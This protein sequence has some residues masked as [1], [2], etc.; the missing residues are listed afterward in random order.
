MALRSPMEQGRVLMFPELVL[1]LL[2]PPPL[3]TQA[4]LM[5]P[6]VVLLLASP[7]ALAVI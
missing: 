3:S 5:F 1:N 6:M 7:P 2:Q 4:P